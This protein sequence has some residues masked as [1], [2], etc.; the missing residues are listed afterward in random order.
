MPGKTYTESMEK[1]KIEYRDGL[2]TETEFVFNV[3]VIAT[4]YIYALKV[5]VEENK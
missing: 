4:N 5:K 1:L 2:I 3:Q